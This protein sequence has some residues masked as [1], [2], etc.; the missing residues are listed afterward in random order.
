MAASSFHVSLGSRIL[1]RLV[2][3]LIGRCRMEVCVS[4]RR[5]ELDSIAIASVDGTH[6]QLVLVRHIVEKRSA[7]CLDIIIVVCIF[8]EL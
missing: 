8:L 3:T 5:G 6:L 2:H 7:D 1:F 4:H